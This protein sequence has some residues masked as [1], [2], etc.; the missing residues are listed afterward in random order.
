VW[1][2]K[3]FSRDMSIPRILL[4]RA[5]KGL[6]IIFLTLS[7]YTLRRHAEKIIHVLFKKYFICLT[8]CSLY[9]WHDVLLGLSHIKPCYNNTQFYLWP[10]IYL[11]LHNVLNG[12]YFLRKP[13]LINLSQK[14]HVVGIIFV[15][16]NLGCSWSSYYIQWKLQ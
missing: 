3:Q 6:R 1:I 5:P 2:H 8:L 12:W 4:Y 11:W 7:V 9:Q 16:A 10:R 15:Y 13:F 14:V